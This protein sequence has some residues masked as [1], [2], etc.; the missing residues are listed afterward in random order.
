FFD[1]PYHL[2]LRD[3]VDIGLV[4]TL[5]YLVLA[6]LKGTRAMQMAIGLSLMLVAYFFVRRIGLITI[7]TL[8]DSIITYIVLIV[9]VIFQNDIRRALMRV[10][11]R[12]FLRS[13]RTAKETAVIEEVI[14][15]AHSLAQKRIGALVV[16]ERGASLDE[17]IEPGTYLD[18]EVTKE[19][20]YTI[21][22]PSFEN[23]MHDGAVIIREG[24][25]WQAGAFLPLAGTGSRDRSLGARHRAAI[26]ISE[27]SD[28][29]VVVVSEERGAMSLCFDGNIVR[30]LD[31]QS[32]REALFGLFYRSKRKKKR[33][34]AKKSQRRKS[35]PPATEA[36][37]ITTPPPPLEPRVTTT[38]EGE[39]GTAESGSPRSVGKV[40]ENPG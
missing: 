1:R 14:K 31:A 2:I 16:F 3:C 39:P 30:N 21:F 6:L 12:T 28:A 4:A 29:V 11:S 25:A 20:L 35:T 34:P 23:P 22:I 24:R 5:I 8:L 7:W 18:A 32:L 19:L 36:R 9:V 40:E 13:Q 26:G 15:A 27:E 17:F 33:E 10:G 37:T 38:P